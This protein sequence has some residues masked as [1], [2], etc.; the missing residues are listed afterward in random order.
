MIRAGDPAVAICD[1]CG[2]EAEA[3]ETRN[4]KTGAL[5]AAFLPKGWKLD[6][7]EGEVI[8]RCGACVAAAEKPFEDRREAFDARLDQL[9]TSLLADIALSLGVPIALARR[10]AGEWRLAQL[11]QLGQLGEISPGQDDDPA[12]GRA[13]P[14]VLETGSPLY[15]QTVAVGDLVKR[16]AAEP[17]EGGLGGAIELH[18][19]NQGHGNRRGS[20]H[21]ATMRVRACFRNRGKA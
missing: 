19:G 20:G 7:V 9:G 1:S 8:H 5:T 11:R 15:A 12:G 17:G 6:R 21:R 13:V 10:W 2:E 16:D 4:R 3:V 18:G 14:G